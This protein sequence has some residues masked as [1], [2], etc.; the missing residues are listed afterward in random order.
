MN[1]NVVKSVERTLY[2][3]ENPEKNEWAP[4]ES[5]CFILWIF[6]IPAG[7]AY[8]LLFLDRISK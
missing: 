1:S 7:L 4:N 2:L 5:P 6:W 3:R 8:A